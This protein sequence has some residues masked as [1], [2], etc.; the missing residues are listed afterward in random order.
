MSSSSYLAPII[1]LKSFKSLKK[2][3]W[4]SNST[5]S[6]KNSDMKF[7]FARVNYFKDLVLKEEKIL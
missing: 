2:P 6:H 1:T 3:G 5:K 7:L 4:G